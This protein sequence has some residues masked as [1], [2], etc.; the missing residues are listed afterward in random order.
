MKA[1]YLDLGVLAIALIIF[2]AATFYQIRLPGLYYDEAAD[3]VPAMQIVQGDHNA[4]D[5]AQ[6]LKLGPLQLPVMVMVYVGAVSTYAVLPFYW[7]FGVGVESTRA[8]TIVMAALGLVFAYFFLRDL[9]DRRVAGLTVLLA[10]L[11]PALVMWS[12]M[13]IYVSSPMLTMATGSL[14]C[15]LRWRQRRQARYLY[16]AA[17][18]MGLG[19]SAKL[20]FLWFI[21]AV[22]CAALL[23]R[24]LPLLHVGRW[25]VGQDRTGPE[26]SQRQAVLAVSAFA[27]GAWMIICYN[28]TTLGTLKYMWRNMLTT[29]SG[30]NNLNVVGNLSEE[31]GALVKMLDGSWFQGLIGP[32]DAN[33]LFPAL[34]FLSVAALLVLLWRRSLPWG[35][36]RVAFMLLLVLFIWLQSGFTITALGATHL[37][38]LYPFPQALIVL[39]AFGLASRYRSVLIVIV[40]AVAVFASD[41]WVLRD[42]HRAIT[43]SG[44]QMA[45]SDAIYDLA[46]DLEGKHVPVAAADW[47]FRF[48]IAIITRGRVRPVEVFGWTLAAPQA[49]FAAKIQPYLASQDSLILFHAPRATA[50]QG[51]FAAAAQLAAG[52]QRT[53]VLERTFRQRDGTDII[54]VYRTEALAP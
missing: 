14:F 37:Y 11:H 35:G 23:L 27:A 54:Y 16:G 13:G 41:A 5:M 51:R 12:R 4:L 38:I 18:L 22:F 17:V 19:L 42:Q 39:A 40:V 30:V 48:N 34:F 10:A 47:G 24:R 50:F 44:G 25:T 53:L 33:H 9:F 7:L 32:A 3:V 49:D 1:K 2:F 29:G 31:L 43:R 28:V 26:I 46:A 8:M 45:F 52:M 6:S 21:L 36:R 20:L 15:L